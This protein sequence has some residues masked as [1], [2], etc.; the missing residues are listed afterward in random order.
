MGHI[1]HHHLKDGQLLVDEKIDNNL[2]DLDEQEKQAN[3]FAVHLLTGKDSEFHSNGKWLKA[4]EIAEKA[5]L[6]GESLKIDAGHVILNWAH[7]EY[8]KDKR[9]EWW[10]IASSALNKLYP[11]SEWQ[12]TIHDL[13]LTNIDESEA[14]GDQLDYLYKLMKI[15]E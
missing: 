15:E 3:L 2:T 7:T 1:F 4:K 11:N 14:Q 13:F 9:S 5:K 6:T 8:T 12:K 10:S